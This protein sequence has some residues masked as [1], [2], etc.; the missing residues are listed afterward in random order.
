MRTWNHILSL[1]AGTGVFRAYFGGSRWGFWPY[2][3][4][5]I[6]VAA[7]LIV[8]VAWARRLRPRK[9]AMATALA[10]EL[11]LLTVILSQWDITLIASSSAAAACLL[12]GYLLGGSWKRWQTRRQEAERRWPPELVA[13]V[14]DIIRLRAECNIPL[15]SLHRGPGFLHDG[16]LFRCLSQCMR[17]SQT[18]AEFEQCV[19]ALHWMVLESVDPRA[20]PPP[21]A[22][23]EDKK[24]HLAGPNRHP[25]IE[26]LSRLRRWVRDGGRNRQLVDDIFSKWM[27]RVPAQ[28]P[29]ASPWRQAHLALVEETADFLEELHFSLA[30]LANRTR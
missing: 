26:R 10:G 17:Q 15:A 8:A 20:W 11:V 27:V 19:Q 25:F 6:V 9:A 12:I 13:S 18:Q 24:V 28:K 23:G 2:W 21:S 22:W 30:E 16:H 29:Q 1:L 7:C 4:D 5:W 3:A 14:A